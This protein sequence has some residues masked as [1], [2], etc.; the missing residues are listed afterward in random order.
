V[1]RLGT[2]HKQ[3]LKGE[4]HMLARTVKTGV[5]VV[6]VALML[7]L[8]SPL[9]VVADSHGAASMTQLRPGAE[10]WHT[11]TCSG[12]G[13]V[14]VRMDVDPDGGAAFMIAT[15]DAVHAWEAGEELAVTGRGANNPVEAA[16]LFW[17]GSCKQGEEL[18]LVV[19]YTGDGA[20]PSSYS[21]E[22]SG[23]ELPSDVATAGG[24]A[25]ADGV[26]C[27]LPGPPN[28]AD[29][30]FGY[31]VGENDFFTGSYESDWTGT[32]TGS[33]RDNGLVIWRNFPA[34]G[35]ALLVDLI[36]FDSVEVG[37]KTGGLELYLYGE[38]ETN[39]WDGPWFIADA[40]GELEGLEGRG[41]WWQWQ[42]GSDTG[43]AEGY[44]PVHYSVDDLSGLDFEQDN[45]D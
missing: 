12:S 22:V 15:P 6:M 29:F 42:G 7:G 3:Q 21:L 10:D 5:V 32:L 17:S 41:R 34:D 18:Y 30:D 19:E 37:G 28:P 14:E 8:A 13:T 24:E 45:D 40:S 9:W 44:V 31:R 4:V 27:Y 16:E 26:W 38:R 1:I 23:A 2:L 39:F 35:P 25:G 11:L 20:A 33:S 43:C 36:T